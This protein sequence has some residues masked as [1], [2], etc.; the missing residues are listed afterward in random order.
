MVFC[1][2]DI[3]TTNAKGI[4]L[5]Q[6]G[7]VLSRV[8]I[9]NPDGCADVF[10]YR[11]FAAVM[12]KF[13]SDGAFA[14]DKIY[15]SVTSQ[16]GSFV[17]VDEKLRPV[18]NLY[19]WTESQSGHS[20]A[21]SYIKEHGGDGFYRTTGWTANAWLPVFKL[22]GIDKR[23]YDRIAFVPDFIY[24]QLTGKLV[25][26]IT[27]AQITGLCDFQNKMWDDGLVKWAKID[28]SALPEICDS[29][30]VLFGG[31]QTRWGNLNLVT[32]SHD[33]YAAMNAISLEPD[34][35]IMLASGTAWVVNSRR[36]TAVFDTKS[37][38]L[39]PGRNIAGNNYGNISVVG[40]NV[41]KGFH[42]MLCL[43]GVDYGQLEKLEARLKSVSIP[44]KAFNFSQLSSGQDKP[45][46]IKRYME[47]MACVV[48]KHF[49]EQ[50]FM[51][52]LEEIV[53]TGGAANSGVLPQVLANVC[54]IRVKTVVF[55]ELT[56]YGA[57]KFAAQAAGIEFEKIIDDISICRSYFPIDTQLYRKWYDV[58]INS[59]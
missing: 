59:M 31:L 38:M 44:T 37:S 26:D 48:R 2:I 57:A 43:L 19:L 7:D 13:Q 4:I 16:G 55:P 1:G 33:Q 3:G 24:G 34:R 15:C 25:T 50:G 40:D 45:L 47:C 28:K 17:L 23:T 58:Q 42:D 9:A 12:D 30:R 21:E 32:S 41:G 52:G 14:T 22:K 11:H 8:T 49:V 18:S 36:S 6:R 5:D 46:L 51:T 54:G 29:L 35:D 27:N 39:H 56:A 20:V 10:W 53:L